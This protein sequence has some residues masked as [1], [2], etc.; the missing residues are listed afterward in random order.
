M[1]ATERVR[2]E[3]ACKCCRWRDDC[4]SAPTIEGNPKHRRCA[5]QLKQADQILA[6]KGVR[7]EADDQN[8]LSQGISW[9]EFFE[10]EFDAFAQSLL[11]H[12]MNLPRIKK[13]TVESLAKTFQ[14]WKKM[15][16]KE[17]G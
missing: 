10:M 5:E 4:D 6:I 7:V 14:D 13:N 11:L 8:H 15:E 1:T 9:E 17:D 12:P 3:I 2:E 16:V